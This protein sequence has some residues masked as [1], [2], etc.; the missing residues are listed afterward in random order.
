MARV[1][2]AIEPGGRLSST[3]QGINEV[4]DRPGASAISNGQLGRLTL[5]LV[6]QRLVP[7][8]GVRVFCVGGRAQLNADLL[9]EQRSHESNLLV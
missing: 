7:I 6:R 1:D 5:F 8:G 4:M 2:I 3:Y 9:P